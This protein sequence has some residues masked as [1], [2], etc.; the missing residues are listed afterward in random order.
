MSSVSEIL[1][2]WLRVLDGHHGKS[3]LGC[4]IKQPGVKVDAT[5]GWALHPIRHKER[6]VCTA[7]VQ[8]NGDGNFASLANT[9]NL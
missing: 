9:C 7:L 4:S 2:V 3:L 5:Y 8:R 6:T 1:Q